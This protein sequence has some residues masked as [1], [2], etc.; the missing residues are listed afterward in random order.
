MSMANMNISVTGLFKTGEVF[1]EIYP[2]L[3]PEFLI[4][5]LCPQNKK[6]SPSMMC[7]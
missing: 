2:V 7:I 6:D 5:Q 4:N 3:P 1:Y